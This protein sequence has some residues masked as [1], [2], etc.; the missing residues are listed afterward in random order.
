MQDAAEAMEFERAAALRDRIRALTQVQS[1]QGINP[2]G[3][4]E[5]DVVALHLEGGQACV[6]VFF[7]RAN[8]NWGNRD[9]YPRTGSGAEAAEVLQ[10]FLAQ[11]YDEKE[12]PRLIL[13]SHDIEDRDLL[14]EALAGKAGRKV[15][16]AVPQRGEKAELV[17]GAERNARESLARKMAET[18]TQSRLLNG[19]AEAFGLDQPRRA[20]S[21][22]TTTAT[23]RARM[24]WAR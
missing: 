17:A 6:Q 5:A 4:A 7:I 22:S 3:V 15:E 21:R 16:I 1:A 11:F 24:P 2:Q 9:Y 18:A 23:F 20:A 14:E 13:L 10:A 8:Q 19:L 12:P